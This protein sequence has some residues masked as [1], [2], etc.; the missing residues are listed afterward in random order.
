MALA[1]PIAEV[2][3][4]VALVRDSSNVYVLRNGR[5]GVCVDFGTGLVLDRLEELGLDRIT[6]VLVTHHHRDGVQGLARAVEV[7][8]RIW[9]P[10]VERDLFARGGDRWLERRVVN[11]Y[12]LRQ[13]RFSPLENVEIAGSVAE[14]RTRSYGGIDVY[15]L[16]TPGHTPGSVTYLVEVGGRKIAFSGDL[17]YGDGRV[18]SLAA[19][20][21]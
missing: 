2:A 3:D 13:D 17:V 16:P 5:E 9:V 20:Q 14:Y 21:W 12:D 8:A 10:P 15:A 6:D 19:T 1:A 7:G 18:W 4:G 11:D